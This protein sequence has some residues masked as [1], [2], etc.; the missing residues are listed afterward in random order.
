M[1]IQ[2]PLNKDTDVSALVKRDKCDKYDYM[3]AAVCGVVSG[4]VDAFLVGSPGNS[5]LGNWTD[6]QVDKCVMNF[7]K[8]NGWNDNGKSSS[9]IGFLENHFRVN[10]DQRHGGDVGGLF[11]MSTKNHHMKSLAHSPSPM[12][13]FFSVLN[14]FTGTATFAANGKLVTISSDY[15]LVGGNFISKLF[16]GVANWFGHLMSDIAGSSGATGRGSGIVMPFYEVFNFCTFGNFNP[17]GARMDLAQL[18]TRAFEQGYD[19]R[20]AGAMAIPVILCD[21]SIRLIWSLRRYFGKHL[22]LKECM[23]TSVHDDLRVMLLVGNGALCLVDAA[24]A[25]IHSILA[26]G[27]PLAGFMQIN[28]IAWGKFICLAIKEVCIRVGLSLGVQRQLEALKREEAA[29]NEYLAE[30]EMI[31]KEAF[32]RETQAYNDMVSKLWDAE[33][34]EDLNKSLD[35]IFEKMDIHTPW[36]DTHDSFESF[37]MDPNSVFRLE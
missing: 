30:L 6:T 25:I 9:A 19:A 12:G 20:F 23:P 36:Q 28:L 18:A 7:A 34:D 37:V 21:L 27:N 22:P 35:F 11:N 14:Q 8:M 13:L 31:D 10:Y 4:L 33:T 26:G 16:C 3:T 29:L 2:I 1:S 15:E 24:D 5:V 17:G 32:K